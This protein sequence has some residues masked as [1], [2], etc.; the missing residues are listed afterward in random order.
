M[1]FIKQKNKMSKSIYN[2]KNDIFDFSINLLIF[3]NKILFN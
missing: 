2:V 3:I 1:N